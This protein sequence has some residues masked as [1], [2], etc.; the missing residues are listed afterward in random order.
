VN[1]IKGGFIMKKMYII[2]IGMFLLVMMCSCAYTHHVN[3]SRLTNVIETIKPGDIVYLERG[4]FSPVIVEKIGNEI[5]I[6]KWL[7]RI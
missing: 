2:I 3:V 6:K 4:I 1:K 5:I 7:K